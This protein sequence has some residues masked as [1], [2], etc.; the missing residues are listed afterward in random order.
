MSSLNFSSIEYLY[1]PS[2][3]PKLIKLKSNVKPDNDYIPHYSEHVLCQEGM[4]QVL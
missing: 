3:V 4:V 2:V 1:V